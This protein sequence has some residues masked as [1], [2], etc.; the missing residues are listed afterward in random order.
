MKKP[1]SL[2]EQL[3]DYVRATFRFR[4]K[5]VVSNVNEVLAKN[6][7]QLMDEES[8]GVALLVLRLQ[9]QAYQDV[10]Q[11]LAQAFH[12]KEKPKR[13]L[14]LIDTHI[15]ELSE[16]NLGKVDSDEAEEAPE[17]RVIEP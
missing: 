7:A 13:I 8:K 16:D 10:R 3:V 1:T 15:A 11:L 17:S 12:E 6:V 9:R 2:G 5:V 4:K 14:D